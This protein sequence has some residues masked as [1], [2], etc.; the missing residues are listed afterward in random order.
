MSA[1]EQKLE[2]SLTEEFAK[3]DPATWTCT[4]MQDMRGKRVKS[5]YIYIIININCY[6]IQWHFIRDLEKDLTTDFIEKIRGNVD[7]SFYLR[8]VF[9]YQLRNIEDGTVI[10]YYTN[11]SSPWIKRLAE[12][13]E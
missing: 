11:H 7:T 6:Y 2:E 5:Y 13:E 8:H 12:A 9:S 10:L 1:V 4:R 3:L